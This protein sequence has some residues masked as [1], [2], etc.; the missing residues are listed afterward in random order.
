MNKQVAGPQQALTGT[1][2]ED[3]AAYLLR[4]RGQNLAEKRLMAAIEAT[5]RRGFVAGE[6]H[7]VTFL[8]RMI[9]I[10]CGESI[11]GIDLQTRIIAALNIEKGQ[12]VLEIGTG[13]G[14]TSAVMA[15]L[16]A[17]VTTVD[18]YRTL[19]DL[20]KQRHH[21]LGI[22]NVIARQ[23]D[24]SNGLPGEGP[25]DRIVAWAAFAELPRHFIDVMGSS[26]IMI[27]PVGKPEALQTLVKLTKI[28]SRFERDD[29]GE[30]RLQPLVPGVAA[31]L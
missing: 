30:V 21:A 11:E 2:R 29:L 7:S 24:G 17:R 20:A 26:G 6:Y 13:S 18:R 12:R 9:P 3:F 25:F 4:M 5:P 31:A 27:A 8:N 19:I 16:A 10:D 23:A 28:G 14:F 15:R 1:A 22:G